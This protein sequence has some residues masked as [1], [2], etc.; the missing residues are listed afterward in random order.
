MSPSERF[1]GRKDKRKKKNERKGWL[2]TNVPSFLFLFL[3]IRTTTAISPPL[4][5]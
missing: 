4:E 3:K 5:D 1:G 2:Q